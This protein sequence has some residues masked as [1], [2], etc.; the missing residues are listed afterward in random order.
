MWDQDI[1]SGMICAVFGFIVNVI[2]DA[3]FFNISLGTSYDWLFPLTGYVIVIASFVESIVTISKEGACF[4][5]G[6]LIGM[7]IL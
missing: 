4:G 3:T 5:I 1:Y 2:L 7:F 6:Y